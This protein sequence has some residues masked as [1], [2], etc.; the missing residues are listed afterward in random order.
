MRY[1]SC[2]VIN[3]D[4]LSNLLDEAVRSEVSDDCCVVK[5]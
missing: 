4:V 5:S 3:S 1:Y 2:K